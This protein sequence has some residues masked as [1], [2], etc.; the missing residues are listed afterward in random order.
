GRTWQSIKGDL[1]ERGN[2]LAIAEDHVN[3]RLLF[4]GTEFGLFV[5]LDGGAK[6]VRLRGGLP[7][8]AVKDLAIQTHMNDLAVGTFGR[9]IYILDDYTPLRKLTPESLKGEAML[10][11]VREAIQY[12]PS[13][14]YG[15]PGKAAQGDAFYIADNPPFG[16]TFTYYLGRTLQTLKQKRQAAEKKGEMPATTHDLLRAEAEEEPP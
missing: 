5:T 3:P 14:P 10:F 6:W 12:I 9:G 4:V 15:G 1:P 7:T 16:A 11:P 8:I 2:V 13:R